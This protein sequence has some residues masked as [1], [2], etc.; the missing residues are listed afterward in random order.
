M[1]QVTLTR[2][3]QRAQHALQS[4]NQVQTKAKEVPRRVQELR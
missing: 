4:V 1:T 2:E 3:Q